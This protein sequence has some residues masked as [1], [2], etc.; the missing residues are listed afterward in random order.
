MGREAAALALGLALSVGLAAADDSEEITDEAEARANDAE[1][2]TDETD[3]ATGSDVAEALV[4]KSEAT[5]DAE[6]E[7]AGSVA[8]LMSDVA[9]VALAELEGVTENEVR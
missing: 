5:D 8:V 3:A 9:G 4:D 7:E 2:R 6:A 1:E